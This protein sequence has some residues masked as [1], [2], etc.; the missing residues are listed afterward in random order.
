MN[1]VAKK[2]FKLSLLFAFGGLWF[3]M[4]VNNPHVVYPLSIVNV[5]KEYDHEYIVLSNCLLAG[6]PNVLLL[7]CGDRSKIT[8]MINCD[9]DKTLWN[10]IY[11]PIWITCPNGY[12]DRVTSKIDMTNPEQLLTWSKFIIPIL[13]H[14]SIITAATATVFI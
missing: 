3:T 7:F 5:Q 11:Q 14:L 10:G 12:L 4:I 8:R 13:W 6:A 9:P 1:L 2:I